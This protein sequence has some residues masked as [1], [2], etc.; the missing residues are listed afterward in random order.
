MP[1]TE[2]QMAKARDRF[3]AIFGE[4][5]ALHGA[6]GWQM[7]R[8][9]YRLTQRLGF[10]YA[11]DTRGTT[12][13]IPVVDAEIVNCPQFPTTLPTLDELIGVDG[14]NEHNVAAHLLERTRK[15]PPAGHVYTLHAELEGAKLAPV[16]EALLRGWREQGYK[17]VALRDLVDRA[18]RAPLAHHRVALAEIPGRSGALAVQ[19]EPFLPMTRSS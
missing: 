13:F 17:L 7:N 3:I 16:L 6:A 4:A 9:A 5:P 11:S 12:P 2:A 10:R 8:H 1:W 14:I 15:I 18:T 19:A